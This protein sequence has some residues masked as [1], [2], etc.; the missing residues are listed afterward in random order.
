MGQSL[1]Q[2]LYLIITYNDLTSLT[3]FAETSTVS[4][5]DHKISTQYICYI[6]NTQF[7]YKYS[8]L[9]EHITEI[10]DVIYSKSP[11]GNIYHFEH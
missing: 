7:K 8:N 10:I 11:T 6:I 2:W 1:L 5:K 3:V 9:P 4:I